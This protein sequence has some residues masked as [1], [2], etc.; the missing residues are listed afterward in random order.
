MAGEEPRLSVRGEAV[1][2]AEPELARVIVNVGARDKSRRAV[3]D[4][5]TRR[6]EECLTL[7]KSYGDAVESVETGGFTVFPELRGRRSG[8]KVA[9]YHGTVRLTIVMNEFGALGELL[10]RLA[11]LELASVEGPRW[12][13]RRDSE[14]HRRAREEAARSAVRRA[15]EYAAA[16]GTRVTGLLEMSDTAEPVT[17][18]G[19]E[20]APLM[21][22]AAMEMDSPPPLDLEPEM[23]IVRAQVQAR[24][25]LAPPEL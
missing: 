6:D 3:L 8:E 25:T 21:R 4:R 17:P 5:L 12:E 7:V 9:R 15:R 24:F 19:Y 23:Q 22:A 10:T 16:L 13:L 20:S 11:D 2:E 1:I 18:F 14:V